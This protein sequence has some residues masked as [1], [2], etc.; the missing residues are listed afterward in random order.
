M[1]R[2]LDVYITYSSDNILEEGM[3]TDIL[4]KVKNVVKAIW[5]TIRTIVSK[6]FNTIS[7]YFKK[8]ISGVKQF[9]SKKKSETSNKTDK[10]VS[11]RDSFKKDVESKNVNH[12]RDELTTIAHSD[13]DFHT[14]E[15]DDYL[16]YAKDAKIEDLFDKFDGEEFKPKDEWDEKYW[17]Y[18]VSSLMDNF[19]KERIDHLKEVGKYVYGKD[20]KTGGSKE[21]GIPKE[22]KKGVAD[23]KLTLVRIMLKDQALLNASGADSKDVNI[24]LDYAKSNI[25]NLFDK[26]DNSIMKIDEDKNNWDKSYM[27]KVAHYLIVNF[28]KERWEHY[29]KVSK[30]V[31]NESTTEAYTPSE[32]EKLYVPFFHIYEMITPEEEGINSLNGLTIKFFSSQSLYTEKI[33]LTDKI[34]SMFNGGKDGKIDSQGNISY[35]KAN[36]KID[37]IYKMSDSER[38]Y[39]LQ[40][41]SDILA[42][43]DYET[44]TKL[45][46]RFATKHAILNGRINNVYSVLSDSNGT[47]N[48]LVS[49][50]LAMLYGNSVK[51][52]AFKH[53]FNYNINVAKSMAKAI[54][55]EMNAIG[56]IFSDTCGAVMKECF[57]QIRN[58]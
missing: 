48:N 3:F 44:M 19:C 27:N 52:Y 7:K 57:N 10:P 37:Q 16:Q 51:A 43:S 12:I 13:R 15:F 8:L 55:E 42:V 28:S 14:S 39:K 22:F 17:S 6:I 38:G 4:G 53:N 20:K 49:S 29:L 34:L 56:K 5:N 30:Y 54:I 45:N 26:H 41:A 31:Y 33:E 24:M 21:D 46:K 23:K 1:S 50:K 25:S 18:I 9:F 58:I 47:M 36:Q 40:T 11:I 32:D 2:F 35:I